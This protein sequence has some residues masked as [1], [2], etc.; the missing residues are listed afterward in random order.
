MFNAGLNNA[1]KIINTRKILRDE[2]TMIASTGS[3]NAGNADRRL[4][5]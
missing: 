2:L 5:I 1:N 3:S 4:P